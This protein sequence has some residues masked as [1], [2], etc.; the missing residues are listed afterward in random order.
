MDQGDF[1]V[2]VKTKKEGKTA[3]YKFK[4]V[5]QPTKVKMTKAPDIKVGETVQFKAEIEPKGTSSGLSWSSSDNSIA[6]VD[7]D[8]KVYGKKKDTVKITVKTDNGKEASKKIK[9]K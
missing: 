4:A 1:E 6:T 9:V 5:D 7:S 3:K 8:G 2:E